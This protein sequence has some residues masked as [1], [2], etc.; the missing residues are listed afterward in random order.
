[1][2][3]LGWGFILIG[4]ALLLVIAELFL[5]THG[6]LLIVGG[7]VDLIGII[8]IFT[9]GDYR[10]GLATLAGEAVVL[11]LL[12]VLAFYVWPH[13]PMGRRLIMQTVDQENATL[14][15][16]NQEFEALRGRIG[17]AVS[18]LRPSGVVE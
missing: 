1:M 13:T 11:P 16:V 9:Y 12:A 18:L 2:D 7:I 14:A 6:V 8:M 17:K 15:S 5:T 3:E 10:I 4:I